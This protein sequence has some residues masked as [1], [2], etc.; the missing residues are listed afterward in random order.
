MAFKGINHMAM[1]T[2]DM[3]KT[4]I[5]YRDVLGMPLVSTIGNV[6]GRYPYRHYFFEVGDGNTI[7]FFEWPG[8]VEEFHKPAG[9]PAQGRIQFD[10]VSF[11]VEDEDELLKLQAR[12][13]EH[14]ME[15]HADAFIGQNLLAQADSTA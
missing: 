8:M 7:A 15:A 4:T 6:P 3:E 13:K 1:V 14:G 5:F 9:S 10:H 11:N 2:G 12:L